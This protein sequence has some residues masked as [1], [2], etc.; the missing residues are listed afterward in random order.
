MGNQEFKRHRAGKG[1]DAARMRPTRFAPYRKVVGEEAGEYAIQEVLECGHR[2]R[3]REDMIGRTYVER[4]RCVECLQIECATTGHY[5]VDW[6][7]SKAE[8]VP[9]MGASFMRCRCTAVT[10]AER[11]IASR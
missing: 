1:A 9:W 6:F 8:P 11:E 4:R 7:A 5:L 2:L 10:A 3:P